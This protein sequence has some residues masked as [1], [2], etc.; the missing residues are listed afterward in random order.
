MVEP[1]PC[2]T[3]PACGAETVFALRTADTRNHCHCSTC[4][5]VWRDEYPD[6]PP[7]AE[8][9]IRRKRDR[10]QRLNADSHQPH[11]AQP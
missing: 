7:P 5:H 4:G 1:L 6:A 10:R 11:E 9:R 8:V 3:C 2:L